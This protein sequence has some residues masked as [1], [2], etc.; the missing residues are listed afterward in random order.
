MIAVCLSGSYILKLS[1]TR[2]RLRGKTVSYLVPISRR[3]IM[4]KTI[5]VCEGF[6][7]KLGVII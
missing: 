3:D 7:Y 4:G 5:E 1:I 2:G 6:Y